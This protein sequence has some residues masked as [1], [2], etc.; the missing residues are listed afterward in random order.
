MKLSRSI[1]GLVLVSVLGAVI[2]VNAQVEGGIGRRPPGNPPGH[3]RPPGPP[4]PPPSPGRPPQPPPGHHRPEILRT[5]LVC[6]S[7]GYRYKSCPI[8]PGYQIV[9]VRLIQEL[10]NSR[11]HPGYWGYTDD[12]VWV[13]QGCRGY[14]EILYQAYRRH[15]PRNDERV[16]DLFCKSSG[17][18]YRSCAPQ[19]F[20]FITGVQ[21]IHARNNSN[22]Q[23]GYSW[24]YDQY[25][26]WVD[27]GCQGEFRVYGY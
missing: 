1:L 27:H 19:S 15:D 7:N 10:D 13:D 21:F 23:E 25:Q 18:R 5:E 20:R 4:P 26:V 16:E 12:S 6:K 11:C 3:T 22:C 24:G 17:Y 8:Q 9:N 2:N 14:F